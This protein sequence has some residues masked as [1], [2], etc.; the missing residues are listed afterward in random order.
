MK[1]FTPNE[2]INTLPLV[3]RIVEDILE[4]GS[5]AKLAAGRVIVEPESK[6]T[7]EALKHE[8]SE[9]IAELE[10]IGCLY[11]DWNFDIGLVDFPAIIEGEQVLLCWRSD[12]DTI[13]YYHR[14]Q[15]GYSGRQA[16]P[17]KYFEELI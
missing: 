8:I 15:D 7:L 11:K 4:A 2:A 1:I 3:S 17:A 12:E 16:I 10:E 9:L 5:K 14:Y 6:A 13:R